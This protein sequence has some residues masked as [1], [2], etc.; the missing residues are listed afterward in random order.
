MKSPIVKPSLLGRSVCIGDFLF[1]SSCSMS[2]ILRIFWSFVA[3]FSDGLKCPFS[4]FCISASFMLILF[5]NSSCL[6]PIF[7][8]ASLMIF[9]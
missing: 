9:A 3:I 1:S 2:F 8:L 5:A 7:S 6:S 4:I